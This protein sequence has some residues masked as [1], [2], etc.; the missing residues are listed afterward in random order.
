MVFY[1]YNIYIYAKAFFQDLNT[2]FNLRKCLLNLQSNSLFPKIR[3]K[4]WPLFSG[5]PP[6]LKL[7]RL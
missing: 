3:K 7:T 1:I 2:C 4:N 6:P 5:L